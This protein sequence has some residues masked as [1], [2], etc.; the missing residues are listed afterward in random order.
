MHDEDSKEFGRLNSIS[1]PSILAPSILAL[2]ILALGLLALSILA[3]GL[4]A[5]SILALGLLALSILALYVNW[6]CSLDSSLCKHCHFSI[7]VSI[8]S[9]SLY[10]LMHI[11]KV[12]YGLSIIK[13]CQAKN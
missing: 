13:Y 4:L 3:L 8:Y 6:H 1:A 10:S 7:I 11:W 2:S 5:P 9:Y 12:P